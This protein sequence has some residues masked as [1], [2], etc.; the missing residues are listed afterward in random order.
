MTLLSLYFASAAKFGAPLLLHGASLHHKCKTENGT[1]FKSAECS[2][3]PGIFLFAERANCIG[4]E[5]ATSGFDGSLT[6][7]RS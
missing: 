5:S 4:E 7:A 3:A 1:V 2:I 6:A